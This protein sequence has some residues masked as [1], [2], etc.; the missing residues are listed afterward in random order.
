MG[1]KHYQMPDTLVSL[2]DQANYVFA[3]VFNVEMILKLL[4]LRKVYFYTNWNLFDMLI[5]VLTNM[6]ILLKWL[7]VQ[8]SIS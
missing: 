7:N 5:V 2:A 8:G 6:G 4:G 3:F 1:M